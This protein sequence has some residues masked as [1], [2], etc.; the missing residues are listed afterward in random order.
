MVVTRATGDGRDLAERL[1][2]FGA[3]VTAVPLIATEPPADGGAALGEAVDQ[4]VAGA[5]GWVVISS[6]TGARRLLAVLGG[7][8]PAARVAAVGPGTAEVLTDAGVQVDLVPE[9]HVGEGL[10]EAFPPPDRDPHA[11]GDPASVVVVRAAVA[12]DVVPD[13]LTG[14]GWRVRVVEA[15]RTV[16][17]S[18][19]RDGLA[20]IA[21][22]EVVTL[23]SSSTAD[24]LAE[25]ATT[26][27]NL[28]V[29][30]VVC[31]GPV[32][33]ATASARGLQVAAVADPHSL[34]GLV[35]AVVG[36]LG[37]PVLPPPEHP[38]PTEGGPPQSAS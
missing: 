33:A 19:D 37:A 13:G 23:T 20:A 7:R 8:R 34:D 30:P 26:H 14:A 22:A 2:A 1:E 12:R 27:P 38:G 21:V 10:V 15:Y 31:I 29:P 24:A 3:L 35:A 36:V 9:R 18:V 5:H 6:P 28:V 16:P 32:T 17:A 4:L 11:G 25:L